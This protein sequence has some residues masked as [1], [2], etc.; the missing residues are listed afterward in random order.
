MVAPAARQNGA[1]ECPLRRGPLARGLHAPSGKVRLA[2]GPLHGHHP[3]S[4]S[5][6]WAFNALTPP[7]CAT[8]L[9]RW[10]SRPGVVPP[11]PWGRSSP[12]LCSTV[13]R[14]RC[15]PHDTVPPT[16]VRLTRRALEGGPAEPSNTFPVTTQDYAVTSSRRERSSPTLSALCGHPRHCSATPGTATT[17]PTLLERTGT[18]RRHACHCV[19]YGPPLTAHSNRPS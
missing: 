1:A 14:G 11:T 17:S 5:C 3:L 15:Q 18:G 2:R 13:W 4:C 7:D 8:T 6:A 19:S 9:T 12:P 16:S 10:E